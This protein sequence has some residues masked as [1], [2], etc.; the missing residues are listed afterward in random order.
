MA[1]YL[2]RPEFLIGQPHID[3]Q[4]RQLFEL[5]DQLYITVCGAQDSEM[6]EQV[7]TELI[8][9][10]R[11][12]FF[13]EERIMRQA[14]YDGLEQHALEH[15]QLIASLEQKMVELRNDG[16]LAN[17]ELLD[18]VHRWLVGHIGGSD[19]KLAEL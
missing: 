3:D 12:H 15:Q 8:G 2:W 4:H 19:Q 14:G 9:V 13:D 6:V 1:K 5:L 18:Y 16:L 17:I 10:T 11:A 7:L